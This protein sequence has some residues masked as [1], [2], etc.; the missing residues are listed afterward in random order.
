M[1]EADLL[2][3][4]FDTLKDASKETR[5]LCQAMLTNQNNIG[6]YIKNLP[7]TDLTQALKEHSKESANNIG[8]CTETVESTTDIILNEVKKMGLKVRTMIV[9]VSVAF[10]LFTLSALVGVISYNISGKTKD[11]KSIESLIDKKFES[12][13]EE[14]NIKDNEILEA[15]RRLHPEPED[16][17]IKQ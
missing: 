9:V 10:S 14:S 1:A 16:K 13:L 8:T 7:M 12:I 5:D 15:I 6:N 3:K 4:L 17:K 2:I 11:T